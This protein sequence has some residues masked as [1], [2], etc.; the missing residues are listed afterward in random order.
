MQPEPPRAGS[1]AKKRLLA[2]P[3]YAEPRL[4]GAHYS[5]HCAA[6]ADQA[7][8]AVPGE[9]HRGWPNLRAEPPRVSAPDLDPRFAGDSL[10]QVSRF[11]PAACR[12]VNLEL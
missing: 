4:R 10:A 8:P 2:A 9:G 12:F 5:R 1:R 11:P 7:R 6:A 3:R